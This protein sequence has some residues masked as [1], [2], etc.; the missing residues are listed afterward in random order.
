ME[1]IKEMIMNHIVERYADASADGGNTSIN[2]TCP[3]VDNSGYNYD[4]PGWNEQCVNPVKSFKNLDVSF[5]SL[6]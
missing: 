2:T 3:P 4:F 6:V 5:I 1:E